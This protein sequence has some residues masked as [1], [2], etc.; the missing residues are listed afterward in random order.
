MQS[1]H[2]NKKKEVRSFTFSRMEKVHPYKLLLYL[3]ILG[4]SFIFIFLVSA[5]D[6][7]QPYPYNFEYFRIPRAFILSTLISFAS[8]FQ[9]SKVTECFKKDD[10]KGMEFYYG[11]SIF[12]GLIFL[13][14]QYLGWVELV[15]SG[16]VVS[17]L[18]SDSYIYFIFGLH[19]AHFILG[20]AYAGYQLY[21]TFRMPK[22]PVYSLILFTNPFEKMKIELL[23]QYWHFVNIAWMALFLYFLFSF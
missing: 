9:I 21:T 18:D 5:Y 16:I 19:T 12:M 15:K 8:S 1:D 3:T 20:L 10:N 14:I 17:G 7:L 6:Y 11:I 22:D 2:K 4:S 23:V 13:L